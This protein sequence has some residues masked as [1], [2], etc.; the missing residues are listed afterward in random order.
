MAHVRQLIRDKMKT[1]LT[2]LST[3]GSSV[4]ISRVYNHKTLP[5]L[6]IYTHDEQSS[7][8]LDNVTFG[9]TN[10]HRLL[11]IVVEAR[12]KAT[13]NVDKT[14]DTISAEVE[15]ALFASGDTTLDG[16]CKYFEFNGLEIELS[17]EQEQ[18]VGLMTMR[19][20][21]LYRVDKTDVT[22]LIS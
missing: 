6:A 15:T 9:S 21:A 16:K 19:F 8:D 7:D 1:L 11:N 12:A 17:G 22:T 14:L 3:T 20:S 4:Y 13:A 5:A 18:P 2:G 10:Q